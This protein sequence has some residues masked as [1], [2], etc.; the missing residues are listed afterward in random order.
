MPKSYSQRAGRRK[1]NP[2]AAGKPS[3]NPT[4]KFERDFIKLA[5]KGEADAGREILISIALA[6]VAGRF[7]SLFFPFLA[8]CLK[9]F[10]DGVPLER[11]LCVEQVKKRGRSRKHDQ[12]EMA[13]ADILLRDYA[14][15]RPAE[16][17]KWLEGILGTDQ[18]KLLSEIRNEYDGRENEYTDKP[19]MESL[20]RNDL[21]HLS[22][23]LRS[24]VAKKLSQ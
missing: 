9:E 15:L 3:M 23:S 21:L 17:R 18:N 19:L 7:N 8:D 12:I 4:E 14:D 1:R 13:A 6:I 10:E 16:A 20:S 5:K 11:A 2:K 24:A 22:G